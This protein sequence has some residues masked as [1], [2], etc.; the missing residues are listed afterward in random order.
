MRN[1]SIKQVPWAAFATPFS[2]EFI[3]GFH[4]TLPVLRCSAADDSQDFGKTS[5]AVCV[6]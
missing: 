6:P 2:P 4:K 1:V 3:H 5:L